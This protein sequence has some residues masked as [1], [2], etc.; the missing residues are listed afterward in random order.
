[1]SAVRVPLTKETRLLPFAGPAV[2][3]INNVGTVLTDD[4][5]GADRGYLEPDDGRF[6]APEDVFAWCG[7]GVLLRRAYLD[8]VGQLDE[9]LF[10]YY[11]DLELSWR[12]TEPI[13]LPTGEQRRFLDD[14][15]EVMLRGFCEREG[16]AR[17]GFGECRG[18]VVGAP[19]PTAN[20]SIG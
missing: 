10:V 18:T 11:E 9:R 20:H 7:A 4:K 15:D 3:V 12:G 2:E 6:G 14:G 13:T 5:H 16:F 8:E 17:I 1:M 19:R